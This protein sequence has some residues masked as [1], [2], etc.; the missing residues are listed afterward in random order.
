M[1]EAITLSTLQAGQKHDHV[2]MPAVVQAAG[3]LS[4]IAVL[5]PFAR[6]L[7]TYTSTALFKCAAPGMSM[8]LMTW[9]LVRT[10][11]WSSAGIPRSRRSQRL[12]CKV[13][14]EKEVV[15]LN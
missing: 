5:S 4:P 13:R 7:A 8:G 14:W 6:F 2:V 10:K 15:S 1:Y 3:L 12:E 9:S 11:A